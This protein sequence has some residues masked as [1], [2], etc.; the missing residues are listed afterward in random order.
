LRQKLH[1]LILLAVAA[2]I[3]TR[4]SLVAAAQPADFNDARL[5]SGRGLYDL[6]RYLEAI[7][8]FR[9]AA[10]GSLDHPPRLSECLA[11]LI[12]AQSAAGR[13][14][15][16]DATILRFLDL[17]RR[18]PTYPPKGLEPE[19]EAEFRALLLRRVP[20]NTL[21]GIPSLAGL[22]ETEEQKIARLPAPDRRKALE[23]AA[24]RDPQAVTWPIALA[25]D[26]MERSD[27]KDAEKWAQKALA[28]EP[29]SPDARALSGQARILRGHLAEG[30]ADLAALPAPELEKRP[31]LYA[32]V[33]VCDVEAADW[34]G[35]E[36]AGRKIPASLAGRSDVARAQQKL[37]AQAR[38]TAAQAPRPTS[39]ATAASA[40][41]VPPPAPTPDAAVLAA[42]SRDA[43]TESRRLVAAGRAGEAQKVLSDA[44]QADP[45]NRELRLALLEAACLSRAYREGA[46]QVSLVAPFG[47]NEA[48]SMFYAA[49][50]LY[51]TGK[52]D[53][54]RGLMKR[55]VP[56]VSGPLVDEYSRKILGP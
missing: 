26:A 55:A 28:I 51:E 32:D 19:R 3:A 36:E 12:L 23:S 48:P 18:F 22:V 56:R 42:R 29:S 31:E 7:D 20:E 52:T 43:L 14:D 11:R 30:C 38:R 54:A 39:P 24:R 8:Q 35:A 44:L 37:A 10:F 47:E 25:R 45:A 15:D 34:A 13:P 4:A 53:E 9:V 27:P 6:Q 46:V 33:F 16:A 17:Q 41:R 5:Q 49:V 50:V 21:L 2:G 1:V 40:G